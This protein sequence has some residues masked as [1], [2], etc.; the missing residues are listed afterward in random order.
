MRFDLQ[1]LLESCAQALF[2]LAPMRARAPET[3]AAEAPADLNRIFEPTSPREP[4]SDWSLVSETLDQSAARGDAV[5]GLH[6]AAA[7]EIEAAE[8]ALTRLIEEC[9]SAYVRDAAR[10]L[11]AT[12]SAVDEAATSDPNATPAPKRSRAA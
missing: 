11:R 9:P 7:M 12:A 3:R 2:G 8:Y 5:A 6:A 10:R 4:G 1:M